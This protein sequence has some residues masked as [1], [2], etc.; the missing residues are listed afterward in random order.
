MSARRRFGPGLAALALVAASVST[1]LGTKEARAEGI[2]TSGKQEWPGKHELQPHLGY[3]VGFGGDVGNLSGF[4]LGAEYG[5]RFQQYVWF[6]LQ[7]HNIF[8]FGGRDGRCRNNLLENCYRGGWGF[9]FDAGVKVKIPTNIPLVIEVPILIGVIATYNR[10]CQDNGAAVPAFKT[11]VGVRYFLTRRIGVGATA[12]FAFGPNFHA[13][14]AAFCG[15]GDRSYTDFYG[16]FDFSLG[17]E[18]IL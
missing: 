12:N 8:G 1:G 13:S 5:Y 6:D 15:K 10:D 18:F 14:G 2:Q 16:A 3:Q 11:G 17:A 7:L 4:R 9:E